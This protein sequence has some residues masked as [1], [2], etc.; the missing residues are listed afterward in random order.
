M[1]G[2]FLSV[3]LHLVWST[4]RRQRLIDPQWAAR[5][6]SY[7]GSIALANKAKLIEAN[8]EP[9]HIH[10][11]V[12]LPS[13]ISIADLINALKS[14]S[15]RWVRQTFQGRKKFS[16]QEGYGAFSVSRS[17]EKAVIAYIRNQHEHHRKR[18]FQDEMLDLLRRH[19]IEYDPRYVFD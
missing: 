19:G 13:T 16:W 12:S 10:L 2:K 15:S 4:K 18:G 14:N 9:D 7:M 17:R 5:L 11:Y 8:S 1:S 6:Y 3:H